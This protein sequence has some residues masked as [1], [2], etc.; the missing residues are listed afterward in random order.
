MKKPT[1]QHIKAMDDTI[2]LLRSM[3]RKAQRDD[4]LESLLEN[5][6][7]LNECRAV[8]SCVRSQGLLSFMCSS[9]G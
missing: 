7:L 3:T 4:H 9:T 1:S 8:L 5:I 2:E 6:R